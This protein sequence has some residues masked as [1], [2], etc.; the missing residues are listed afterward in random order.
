MAFNFI[1]ILS[2]MTADSCE[3]LLCPILMIEDSQ[4]RTLLNLKSSIMVLV[5]SPT[6]LRRVRCDEISPLPT[7]D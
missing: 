2:L 6:G 7:D 3:S 4:A 1:A 5:I